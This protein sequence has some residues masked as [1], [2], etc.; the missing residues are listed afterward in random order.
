VSLDVLHP[1]ADASP[2]DSENARSLVLCVRH[3]GH[4]LLLTGDLESPGMER[5]LRLA[6]QGCDVLQAPHHG[7]R[8]L[9]TDGLTAWARPRLVVSCQGRP[10]G[11]PGA[12][13]AYTRGGCQ[14]LDT[15]RHGAVTVV[16]HRSGLV[17]ETFKS[18]ERLVLRGK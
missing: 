16:S 17:I 18:R 7:S 8:R 3:A 1:P 14:F 10:R 11:A 6:P 12:P 5:L 9:D 15:W 4:T 13:E 2:D